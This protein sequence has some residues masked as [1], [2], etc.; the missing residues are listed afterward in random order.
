MNS[1]LKDHGSVYHSDYW[2][3]PDASKSITMSMDQ[4]ESMQFITQN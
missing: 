4:D 3:S 2:V 1:T